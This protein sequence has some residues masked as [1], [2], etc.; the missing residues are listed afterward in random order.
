M[1]DLIKKIIGSN[2]EQ[3]TEQDALT[4]HLAL[5]V[6]LLEAAHAD[7]E[8]S[9]EE[10]AH[11]ATTL[12]THFGISED[13][14]Q[15]LLDESDKERGEYVNLFRYTRF[16]NENFSEKQKIEIMESVW[17][18]IL[19]DNHLEAH[20]DHFAHKLANLLGLSHGDLI[21]AK[22]RARKQLS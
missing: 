22:L 6:L 8:C 21:D 16:I 7:G 3:A 15:T 1:F 2:P 17:R 18:I 5:T 10:K 12:V 11:L 9:E 4:A 19:L 14:I 13:E 20:E